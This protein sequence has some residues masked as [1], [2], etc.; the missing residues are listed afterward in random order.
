M[1]DLFLSLVNRCIPAGILIL[2][3]LG[4]RLLFRRL[5]KNPQCLLWIPVGLRLALPFSLRSAASLTPKNQPITRETVTQAASTILQRGTVEIRPAEVSQTA[6]ISAAAAQRSVSV[7]QVLSLIWLVGLAVMLLWGLLSYLRLRKQLAVSLHRS[8]NIYLCDE[9]P[10]PFVLGILRPRIYLPSRLDGMVERNVLAHEQ[11]HIAHR[12]PWWKLLGFVLLSVYWFHPLVWL[13]YWLFCRDLE[14]A[15]DE[16]VTR[17]MTPAEKKTYACCL[18]ACAAP[19]SGFPTCPVAFSQNSVKQRIAGI[20]GKKVTKRWVLAAACI[21]AIVAVVCFATSPRSQESAQAAALGY[22]LEPDGTNHLALS[23]DGAV[24]GGIRCAKVYGKESDR[25]LFRLLGIDLNTAEYSHF[26][27]SGWTLRTEDGANS[28]HI[29]TIRDGAVYDLYYDTDLADQDTRKALQQLFDGLSPLP[30][31]VVDTARQTDGEAL[32]FFTRYLAACTQEAFDVWAQSVYFANQAAYSNAKGSYAPVDSA[33]LLWWTRLNDRLWV[34][35]WRDSTVDH[36]VYAFVADMDG[37]YQ[38]IRNVNEIPDAYM[39]GVAIY[40]Y[41]DTRSEWAENSDLDWVYYTLR[42]FATPVRVECFHLETVTAAE[43]PLNFL[44]FQGSTDAWYSPEKDPENT[45]DVDNI[46]VGCRITSFEGYQMVI[47]ADQEGMDI[48]DDDGS[49]NSQI[50]GVPGDRI[51]SFIKDW[52]L[53]QEQDPGSVLNAASVIVCEE[54]T[55]QVFYAEN[56]LQPIAPGK[57]GQLALAIAVVR[58]VADPEHT[59]LDVSAPDTDPDRQFILQEDILHGLT[60]QDHLYRMLLSGENDSAYALAQGVFGSTALA[61]EKMNQWVDRICYDE[62]CFTDLYGLADGQFITVT[63]LRDLLLQTLQNPTLQAIWQA[64]DY[65][66]PATGETIYSRNALLAGNPLQVTGIS[67]DR[68][69]T[70]GF[71]SCVGD[72]ADMAVTAEYDGRHVLCIVLGAPR[73]SHSS[74]NDPSSVDYWGNYE[75]MEKLL[76]KVFRS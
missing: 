26:Y 36:D 32:D 73:V 5:P 58:E 16:R 49:W 25:E 30:T 51:L 56:P 6:E 19:K 50:L 76:D 60:V 28:Y 37:T 3:V 65:T 20:L 48:Y 45:R 44:D 14:M 46:P 1:T 52:A 13:G 10:A 7:L 71:A 8:E 27:G 15:C 33:E 62:A 69:V 57:W 75:E 53:S 24:L 34:F 74:E 11:A 2:A 23:K 42:S 68:R 54:S 43:H 41:S 63:G 39:E 18:L 21:L 47:R 22:S 38:I 67:Y 29:L 72:L 17:C 64:T 61:V 59:V 40:A 55:E 9:I 35:A 12:D 4:L 70:G 31:P 66:V